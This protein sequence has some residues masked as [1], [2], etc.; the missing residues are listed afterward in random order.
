MRKP[1]VTLKCQVN[2]HTGRTERIVEFSFPDGSGGLIS[3]RQNDSGPIVEVYRVDRS[4]RVLAP[5]E[6]IPDSTR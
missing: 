4:V 1:R 6:N 2:A 3:F 5:P